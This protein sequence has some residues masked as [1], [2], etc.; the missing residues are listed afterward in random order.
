[1]VSG[2]FSASFTQKDAEREWK[3]ISNTLNSMG[4]AEKE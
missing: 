2:K 4:G 1:M 3:K